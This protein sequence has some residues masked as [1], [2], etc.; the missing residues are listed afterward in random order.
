[1]TA[2]ECRVVSPDGVKRKPSDQGSKSPHSAMLHAGY[3][4]LQRG[5]RVDLVDLP[6]QHSPLAIPI[7]EGGHVENKQH[8]RAW[9]QHGKT[10]PTPPAKTLARRR[11]VN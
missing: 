7:R 6:G 11:R 8:R 3:L 9:G 2:N 10:C 5:R 1:M 4:F